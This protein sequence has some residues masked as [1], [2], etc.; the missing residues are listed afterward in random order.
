MCPYCGKVAW[1]KQPEA[2]EA[3]VLEIH[4]TAAK[5]ENHGHDVIVNRIN[6]MRANPWRYKGKR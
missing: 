6:D 3:H 4:G 2:F 1:E 5:A